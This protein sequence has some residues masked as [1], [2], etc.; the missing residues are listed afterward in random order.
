MAAP[1]RHRVLL[2]RIVGAQ[3]LSGHVL[4]E[5]YTGAPENIAAYGPLTDETGTRAFV[6]TVVRV[7]PKGVVAR[8]DD[9]SDRTAAEALKGIRLYVERD[10]LPETG[11]NE[12][13][14]ADLLGLPAVSPDGK[15]I[16][17]VVA[18]RNYG[19]GDLLEVRLE[20][21]PETELVPFTKAFVSEVD[22]AGG[23][24]VIAMPSASAETDS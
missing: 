13:Y 24:V 23:H 14:H 18:L 2:G 1:R 21:S 3:G 5:S 10:R 15:A 20:N 7:T 19:A 6:I 8:V 9:V 22:L 17:R 12:F 4:V 11:P 16:G